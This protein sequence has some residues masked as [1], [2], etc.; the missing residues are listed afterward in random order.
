MSAGKLTEA[1]ASENG[2]PGIDVTRATASATYHSAFRD[3][4]IWATTIGWGRNE[5][6]GHASNA[7]LIETNLTFDERDT[8]FARFEAANKTAHDLAV[9]ESADAFTDTEEMA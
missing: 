8:W 4:T 1:E 9:A 6:S 7:L 2:G 5:E 3:N